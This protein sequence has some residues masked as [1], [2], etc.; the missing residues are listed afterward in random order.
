MID[1]ATGKVLQEIDLSMLKEKAKLPAKADVLNGIA[2]DADN[3]KLYATGKYWPVMF[4]ITVEGIN[5]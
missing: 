2:W 1:P 3:E 4:E 5:R